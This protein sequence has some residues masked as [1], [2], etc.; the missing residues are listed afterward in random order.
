MR[1]FI[2][3][4]TIAK[5]VQSTTKI[6]LLAIGIA[7]ENG[8][9]FYAEN[10]E[11]D[12]SIADNFAIKHVL[13]LLFNLGDPSPVSAENKIFLS[14]QEIAKRVEEFCS[15]DSC[16]EFWASG[17]GVDW[18]MFQQL[19][20]SLDSFPPAFP[21]QSFSLSRRWLELEAPNYSLADSSCALEGVRQA[22]AT[23]RVLRNRSRWLDE[24]M[25]SGSNPMKSCKVMEET[26][27]TSNEVASTI[28]SEGVTELL[29][30][31][32]EGK[33]ITWENGK[34]PSIERGGAN[35]GVWLLLFLESII[36]LGFRIHG[37]FPKPN[38]PPSLAA[39]KPSVIPPDP[40]AYTD[41]WE[42]DWEDE[43]RL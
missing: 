3:T 12:L 25:G 11:A 22:I 31:H 9:E 35:F 19:W 24:Y 4:T 43:L 1:Y 37:L 21:D 33:N 38:E 6:E 28:A 14:M 15:A 39:W 29:C 2:A 32:F 41:D 42:D 16:P 34:K 8:R 36:R 40:C 18:L 10:R 7:A 30:G 20:E 13:P 26:T 23:A 5:R 17:E 27:P